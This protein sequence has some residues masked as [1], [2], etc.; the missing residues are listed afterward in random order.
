M[1]SNTIIVLTLDTVPPLILPSVLLNLHFVRVHQA[2]II[3]VKCF[4]LEH[5]KLLIK[6][7]GEPR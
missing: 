7:R 6:M 4:I 2:D 5:N 1:S 3:I